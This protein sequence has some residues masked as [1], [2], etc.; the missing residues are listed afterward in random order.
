M[1]KAGGKT[2]TKSRDRRFKDKQQE[3]SASE[4]DSVLAYVL[5]SKEESEQMLLM[6][7]TEMESKLKHKLHLDSE[8]NLKD[9]AILDYYTGATY[10]GQQQAYSTQQLS[11]LF[12]IVH[13]LLNRMKEE[14]V[15]LV[16]LITELRNMMATVG[17][18]TS[19]EE[20]IFSTQQSK[21]ITGYL[22]SSLFQHYKL[23]EY[24]FTVPRDEEI[25][26]KDFSIEVPVPDGVPFPKSLD[27]GLPEEVFTSISVHESLQAEAETESQE[28]TGIEPVQPETPAEIDLPP[29]TSFIFEKLTPEDV[30]AVISEACAAVLN[31]LEKD[32]G[33]KITQQE[34]AAVAKICMVQNSAASSA[35]SPDGRE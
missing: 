24:L 10:W 20:N 28:G 26:T 13:T 27:E 35:R 31:N 18:Q 4:A 3:E 9:A 12:T 22:F 21:A 15:P 1:S 34:A 29:N 11:V 14:Q 7:V 8:T 17:R 6:N 30:K 19:P 2:A 5:L 25:I 32:V 23:Y 33:N 16:G